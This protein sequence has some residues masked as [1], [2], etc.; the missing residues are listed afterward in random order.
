MEIYSHIFKML[1]INTQKNEN[2]NPYSFGTSLK[3]YSGQSVSYSNE[4]TIIDDRI[5]EKGNKK[6]EK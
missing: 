5:D 2:Y 4:T 3:G 6:E 1:G